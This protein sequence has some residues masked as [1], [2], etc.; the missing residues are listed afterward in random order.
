M[1]RIPR[2]EH[3]QRPWRIH[4]LTYDFEVE[5]VWSFRTPGAGSDDFPVMLDALEVA[6]GPQNL[7]AV[8]RFLFAIRWK[9]GALF[10]WD[11]V[12][13]GVGERSRS[14]RERMDSD[15]ANALP[16]RESDVTPFSTLYELSD[17]HAEELVNKTVHTVC[18]FGWVQG[19][20]GDYE[21]RMAALVKPNG[22]F[23]KVYM[24]AITP[25]RYFI[26]YPSL[27]RQFEKAW[28]DRDQL[29]G[30]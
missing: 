9:L 6:G 5:D 16:G 28:R 11:D 1:A 2:S 15:L 10:G 12:K 22:V 3:T 24:K 21:L 14:L 18:H 20:N 13:E 7:N 23:G 17:E 25:F 8:S 29:V 30:T 4:H 27:T 19:D 26:V